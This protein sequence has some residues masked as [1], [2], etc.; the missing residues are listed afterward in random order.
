M[1]VLYFVPLYITSLFFPGYNIIHN[2]ISDLGDPNQ[3]PQIWPL[4]GFAHSLLALLLTPLAFYYYRQLGENPSK[5]LRFGMFF[6]LLS[7]VGL[8]GA[9]V[10]PQ[11]LYPFSDLVHL[12]NAGLFMGGAFM[13]LFIWYSLIQKISG[14]NQIV[15]KVRLGIGIFIAVSICGSLIFPAL[16]FLVTLFEW[17]IMSMIL[18]NHALLLIFLPERITS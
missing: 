18:I 8:L 16:A 15:G 6:S 9:G 7:S 10:I 1:L 3:N 17:G 2:Y 12:I 14:F 4:W 13:N 5:Q 11:S